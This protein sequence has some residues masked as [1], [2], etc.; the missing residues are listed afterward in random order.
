MNDFQDSFPS[1][2]LGLLKAAEENT[3]NVLIRSTEVLG[4]LI[5]WTFTEPSTIKAEFLLFILL[6]IPYQ[7]L[8]SGSKPCSFLKSPAEDFS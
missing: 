6:F 2:I 8:H 5:S 3:E 7:T 4:N 1:H